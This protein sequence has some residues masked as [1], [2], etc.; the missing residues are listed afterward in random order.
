ML[1]DVALGTRTMHRASQQTWNEIY[2]GLMTVEIDGWHLTLFND[3]DTI[4][5][6]R[7]LQSAWWSRRDC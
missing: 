7:G 2:N 5:L 6:L 3:S 4:G 1:K